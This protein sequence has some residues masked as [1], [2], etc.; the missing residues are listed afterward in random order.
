MTVSNDLHT[1]RYGTPGNA[2]QPVS[3]PLG[4]GVTIY[5]G[6]IAGTD[7]NGNLKNM[8]TPASTDVVW[9]LVDQVSGGSQAETGPGITNSG[10]SG[11]VTVDVA[12]G[13]FMLL[14]GGSGGDAL[15]Q[16]SIGKTVYVIDSQT[17][18]ATS[19]ST[20]RPVAGVL[21]AIDPSLSPGRE[22]AVKLGSNQSS[23][24]PQ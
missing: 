3:Q 22:F 18:G 8:D 21:I 15:T 4:A 10:G 17:V 5:R 20:T 16:A 12:T 14:N 9:G 11:A 2:S 1:Y 23:G 6:Q 24:G 13:S 19:A 7:T